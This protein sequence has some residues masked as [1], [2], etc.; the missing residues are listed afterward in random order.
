MSKRKLLIALVALTAFFASSPIA[1]LAHGG[2]LDRCGGHT[3]RK[4]GQYHVHNSALYCACHPDAPGCKSSTKAPSQ[5]REQP[6]P[7]SSSATAGAAALQGAAVPGT[8]EQVTVYVTRTGTKYHRDGCSALSKSRIPI[9]LAEATSRYSPC[10]RCG[11]PTEAASPQSPTVSAPAQAPTQ[12]Q[13][14][15][16]CQAITKKG[17]RCKR[18]AKP[19]SNYCWQHGG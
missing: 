9:S 16:Q 15:G 12:P 2:G 7:P 1:A 8:S 4:T 11:P 6:S 3:N 10:S 14:G 18:S 17:T 13:T 19:G 5:S